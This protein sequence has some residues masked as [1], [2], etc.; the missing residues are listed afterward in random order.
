K[1]PEITKTVSSDFQKLGDAVYLVGRS[2][3][4]LGGSELTD[5]FSLPAERLVLNAPPVN[6]EEN[7][8][9]YRTI[10]QAIRRGLLRS[11]HDCS[12]GGMLV[13]LAESAIGGLL[14]VRVEVE[15]I[16]EELKEFGGTLAEFFF[17]ESAGRFVV[18]VPAE[19][20]E[21]FRKTMAGQHC[22]RLGEVAPDILRFT[23][24][25]L[26]ILDVPVRDARKAWKGEQR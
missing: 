21:E 7:F 6:A 13:A 8:R 19:K 9:L 25:G 23:R 26:V 1:V 22:L 20:E 5:T 24:Y 12:E 18:S 14:G 15:S 17:N 2:L 11:C 10:H 3:R 4:E 16:N